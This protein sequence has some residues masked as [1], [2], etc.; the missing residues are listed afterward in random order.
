MKS[1]PRFKPQ[2]CSP[3]P[4]VIQNQ[5]VNVKVSFVSSVT[6]CNW[7]CISKFC[8]SFNFESSSKIR[9]WSTPNTTRQ[10]HLP[11]SHHQ[12]LLPWGAAPTSQS[13]PWLCGTLWTQQLVGSSESE[14]L[15]LGRSWATRMAWGVE[16]C[17]KPWYTMNSLMD[18]T[19]GSMDVCPAS[20]ACFLMMKG[21]IELV[22]WWVGWNALNV[23]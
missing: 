11:S 3:P 2:L 4:C 17:R 8:G 23:S 15:P 5:Q 14:E 10:W 12:P 18:S 22:W 13:H 20:E 19:S 6:L 9:F 7:I 16:I 21:F 1:F